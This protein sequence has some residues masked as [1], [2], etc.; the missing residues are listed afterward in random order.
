MFRH[1]H[2]STHLPSIAQYTRNLGT[3]PSTKS[4]GLTLHRAYVRGNS[5]ARLY[6]VVC[7]A[8]GWVSEY[9][10]MCANVIRTQIR[11][12]YSTVINNKVLVES[13]V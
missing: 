11:T 1:G 6:V 4:I 3:Q 12:A 5:C 9:S 8:R 13:T 2:Q 7:V 10:H